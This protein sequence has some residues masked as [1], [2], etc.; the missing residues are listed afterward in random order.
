[1]QYDTTRH[2]MTTQHNTIRRNT[3]QQHTTQIC[4]VPKMLLPKRQQSAVIVH[5][6]A[7]GPIVRMSRESWLLF[8]I[9]CRAHFVCKFLH[10]S[11]YT[12]SAGLRVGTAL[13]RPV[14]TVSAGLR[15][16]TA[17]YRSMCTVSA[18]ERVGT[19]LHRSMYTVSAGLRVGRPYTAQCALSVQDCG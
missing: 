9:I 15:V 13:H 19:A 3:K 12:I 14:C 17:L 18:G 1:M 10:R 11:V 6:V 8:E 16:R 5:A 2:D 4:S 7:W